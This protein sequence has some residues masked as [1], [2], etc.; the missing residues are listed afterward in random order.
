MATKISRNA[1][2]N[3]DTANRAIT[4]YKFIEVPAQPTTVLDIPRPAVGGVHDLH[5]RGT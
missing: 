5:R 4:L 1:T 3:A 2:H